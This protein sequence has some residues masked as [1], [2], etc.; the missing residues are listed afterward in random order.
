MQPLHRNWTPFAGPQ[1]PILLYATGMNL[2][3]KRA[4][5]STSTGLACWSAHLALSTAPFL[6]QVMES[7]HKTTRLLTANEALTCSVPSDKLNP[8]ISNLI[9]HVQ[10]TTSEP[11]SSS[12]LFDGAALWCLFGGL[13]ASKSGTAPDP[14]APLPL[15]NL[16]HLLGH[17]EQAQYL[18]QHKDIKQF[19]QPSSEE[20]KKPFAHV[21]QVMYMS[22]R[23]LA[24]CICS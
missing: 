20:Y 1:I 6:K 9:Y 15:Q 21:T 3:P 23:S 4:C 22:W 24:Q 8:D 10:T 2:H 11:H 19:T 17:A 5:E 16:S 14:T 18:S 7:R 13:L 12:S